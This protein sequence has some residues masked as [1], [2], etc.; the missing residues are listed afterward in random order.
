MKKRVLSVLLTVCMLLT[1]LPVTATAY[2]SVIATDTTSNP[3]YTISYNKDVGSGS[4]FLTPTV[5]GTANAPTLTFTR[6]ELQSSGGVITS[7][8]TMDFTRSFNLAGSV[9]F[10]ERDGVSFALHTTPQK[11]SYLTSYNT[12]MM[13]PSLLQNW[14]KSSTSLT[15]NSYQNDITNGL[16]WDFM[17]FTSNYG[18][19]SDTR[20]L[21]GAYSYQIKDGTKVTALPDDAGK[22]APDGSDAAL[23]ILHHG[24]K[25]LS[26]DFRLRWVCTDASKA[27]GNLTITMGAGTTFTYTGLDAAS[28]FG[29]LDKARAVYFSFSTFL[30]FFRSATDISETGTTTQ[31]GIDN[32]C[33]TD[34]TAEGGASTVSVAT[35]YYCDANGDGSYETKISSDTRVSPGSTILCRNVIRNSNALAVSP[36]STALLLP[37]LRSY[38]GGSDTTGTAIG[39]IANQKLYWHAAGAA[40]ETDRTADLLVQKGTGP[41][42]STQPNANYAAVTLPAGG[43]G[44]N[45]YSD[46]YA[47]YEYTFTPDR[48][49]ARID[50]T[51]QI[52]LE[53]F[54]PA[55]VDST[56]PL[57]TPTA[58]EYIK[59][60]VP[61]A[62]TDY[63]LDETSTPKTLTIKTARGAAFFSASGTAYLNYAVRLDA[64]ID[65]GGFLWRPVGGNSS[66]TGTFDGQGH[67]ISNLTITT[68]NS[69][70]AG[71]FGNVGLSGT[72]KDLAVS[73][74]V[75]VSG[76]SSCF[77]GGIAG[78]NRGLIDHCASS[79][80]IAV[81]TDAGYPQSYAGGIAG[82][83]DNGTI[84]NCRNSGA[85]T[86]SSTSYARAGGIMGDT[87]NG[88]IYNCF[89]TGAVSAGGGSSSNLAGGITGEAYNNSKLSNCY[90]AG[91]VT[92]SGTGARTGGICGGRGGDPVPMTNCFWLDTA[93]DAV[94]G[95]AQNESI[96]GC[97]TFAGNGGTLTAGTAENCGSAQQ[98]AYGSALLTA[99]NSWVTA[100]ANTDYLTWTADNTSNTNGGYPTFGGLLS[101]TPTITIAPTGKTYNGTP[102]AAPVVSGNT[103]GGT[104]S[105]SFSDTETGEYT[106]GL[107]VNAGTW[108]VKAGVTAGG[109]YAAADSAPASV[110]IEKA[111]QPA[112]APGKTDETIC[113]KADGA[114]T[115]LNGTMEY[116]LSTD[117]VWTTVS[118]TSAS[119][120]AAGTYEIRY[121]AGENYAASPAA[122][123]TIMPG[124]KLT[125]TLPAAQTGYTLT[126]DKTEFGWHEA[127]VLTYTLKPGYTQQSNFAVLVNGAAAALDAQGKATVAAPESDLTAAVAG[128]ADVTAP[129]GEIAVGENTWT[130]FLNAVTFGLFFKETQTVTVTS[131]DTGSGVAKAEYLLSDTAFAGA[132]QVE[133]T[134]SALT[135]DS[136]G[137]GSFNLDPNS[138]QFIYVRL[139]DAVGNS[140][141]LNSEGVVLYTS[142][143]LGETA[144]EFNFDKQ[145]D[146]VIPLTLNDNT[147]AAV[148]SDSG[149][150]AEGTDYTLSGSTLTIGKAY[151]AAAL[152][153]DSLKLTLSF[154]PMG[155][156]ADKD[157]ETAVFTVTRHIHTWDD[158]VVTVRPTI[159]SEGV[160]TDTCT[161]C[162]ITKTETV[163]KLASSLQT[164]PDST[165]KAIVSG[166]LT[167]GAKLIITPIL[168]GTGYDTLM[169]LVNTDQNE[170]VGAYEVTLVGQYLGKLVLTF[171]VD[172]Q[173]NGKTLTICHERKDGTV[174]TFVRT[175]EN[176]KVSVTVDEL[177]PFLLT[178]A[179]DGG[180]TVG[181]AQTGDNSSIALSLSLLLVSGGVL[182]ALGLRRK[183]E[184][185]DR[186]AR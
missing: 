55:V 8:Y 76:S 100:Q 9:S 4:E 2:N 12:C 26:G 117:T 83:N 63:V 25:N 18:T 147:L 54:T 135:L 105:W 126:A 93:A 42:N 165:E 155:V 56:V 131:T 137:R 96:T 95:K 79:A 33:Y 140:A 119:G 44:T 182:I 86:A 115:G 48:N 110:T 45:T 17:Q 177:S 138:R 158:G 166:V 159:S 181:A 162:G 134:W 151:L 78:Y 21:A 174:E 121:A 24:T 37:K 175:A 109:I 82:S 142:A 3:M 107:P 58:A 20:F 141:I 144:A 59:A 89:N 178:A 84:R 80:E 185:S 13:A 62:G 124:R 170:V 130:G 94:M 90:D 16:L 153:G 15:V 1:L 29:G 99:L 154:A 156:A 27:L 173:Y 125:V 19:Y 148:K 40:A 57:I 176:G 10:A 136:A 139:T 132:E 88:S 183:R 61:I 68:L 106:G 186:S 5:S 111:S 92:A 39:S 171:T 36:I 6:N 41:L 75:R 128:V 168:G 23:G 143:A 91:T 50:Q 22:T 163:Q 146:V 103:G 34:T 179:K 7:K 114:L 152:T 112:P 49:A 169:K 72:V 69:G 123:L 60:S 180:S 70:F 47:V 129:T 43:D 32:A 116:R 51:I 11:K 172:A 101:I 28:V 74:V 30:P 73:G 52:E 127:V 133:G 64:D 113:G 122:A 118:G 102:I 46:A 65:A 98:L 85:V 14:S 150:L 149:T 164:I 161:A 31:I 167:D 160:R 120:L 66:F 104:V 35:D 81:T 108:Y 77:A 67:T 38:A 97:G 71:V 145:A 184:R 87:S 157:A 53:P